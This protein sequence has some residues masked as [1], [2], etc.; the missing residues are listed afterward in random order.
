MRPESVPLREQ[1]V[2]TQ[3]AIDA[4]ADAV[5]F[6]PLTEAWRLD[7]VM[8]YLDPQTAAEDV[9]TANCPECGRE[10]QL[11]MTVTGRQSNGLDGDVD[12]YEC[13][14]CGWWSA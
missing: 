10:C 2:T 4:L 13:P 5:H 11:A 14:N 7:P 12:A 9:A 3:E 6:I 1:V 8:R